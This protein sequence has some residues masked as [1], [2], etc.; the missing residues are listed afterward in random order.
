MDK[1]VVVFW[2]KR[3]L[4]S[5]KSATPNHLAM[6]AAGTPYKKR[7]EIVEQAERN[8]KERVVD[9]TR[10]EGVVTCG[11]TRNLGST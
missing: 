8:N 2:L 5:I 9:R 11:Q 4:K 3:H 6:G 1:E 10:M 7:K